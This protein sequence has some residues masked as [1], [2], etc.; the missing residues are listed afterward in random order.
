VVTAPFDGVAGAPLAYP[1][2]MVA[3]DQ[4]D[5]V[6]INQV[7]PVNVAFAVPEASLGALKGAMAVRTIEVAAKVPG[8]DRALSGTV[9]FVDNAVDQSTGTI[10]MKARF[11]NPSAALTPGQ[12]VNLSLPTTRIADAV[13]VPVTAHQNSPTGP[14]VFVLKPDGTVEQRGITLGPVAGKRQVIDQGVAPGEQVVIEGQL[15][16]V[17][18][19]KAVAA[20][21][22][23]SGDAARGEHAGDEQ[24]AGKKGARK[25]AD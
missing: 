18:G 20:S 21:D 2:A 5:L 22:E 9:G 8:D 23:P 17:P 10:V 3:A 13:T 15:L 7:Q 4:T 1:G 12:F 19:A 24:R 16:L 6:V 14:F 11:E 25:G